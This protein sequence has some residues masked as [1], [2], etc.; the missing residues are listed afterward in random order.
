MRLHWLLVSAVRRGWLSQVSSWWFPAVCS[1]RS[2]AD[3]LQRVVFS[4]DI[5]QTRLVMLVCPAEPDV[6]ARDA[7]PLFWNLPS[8]FSLQ[9]PF[10]GPAA[11]APSQ[12]YLPSPWCRCW[13]PGA[14]GSRAGAWPQTRFGKG[15]DGVGSGTLVAR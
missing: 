3:G 13:C 2:F 8:F 6:A 11:L 1:Q 7:G 9:A 12:G 14:V 15:L 10:C 4:R 5:L